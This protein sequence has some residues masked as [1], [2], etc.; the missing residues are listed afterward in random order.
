MLFQPATVVDLFIP[1][2]VTDAFFFFETLAGFVAKHAGLNPKWLE[3][4]KAWFLML[5]LNYKFSRVD[6]A[7]C[8]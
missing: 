8:M 7:S 3:T 2:F 4:Q 6:S 1:P 5:C